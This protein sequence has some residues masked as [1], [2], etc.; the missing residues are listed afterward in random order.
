[1]TMRL[2]KQ[3]ALA[4]GIL[5]LLQSAYA[6]SICI[7]NMSLLE[8][9]L[10]QRNARIYWA[11]GGVTE[12]FITEFS[13]ILQPC[14]ATDP[15]ARKQLADMK[16]QI[17]DS[18]KWCMSN[19]QQCRQH[20]E[21]G[22]GGVTETGEPTDRANRRAF[23]ILQEEVQKILSGVSS[24]NQSSMNSS[25]QVNMECNEK[26]KRAEGEIN[27]ASA[28]IPKG[29]AAHG[30]GVVMC[31]AQKEASIIRNS[32]TDSAENRD[33]IRSLKNIYQQ[34]ETA[35]RQL[36]TGNQ[37]PASSVC[38][39][40]IFDGIQQV[41][42]NSFGQTSQKSAQTQQAQQAA[43]Q[44]QQLAQQNQARADKARQG[45]RKTNNDAAQAHSCIEIDKEPG[46][47]GAFKNTCEYKVNFYTC[48]YKPKIK[49][50]GFNWSADFDCE[51]SQFGLHTPDG[52]RSVAAHN[53]NTEM[54]YWFACKA[55]AGPVDAVFVVGKGIEARCH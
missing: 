39:A 30:M 15:E 41:A 54:V 53:R 34:A 1:M 32:C 7:K 46:L 10:M 16:Q 42:N 36:G 51:K 31:G 49:E 27:A 12:K 17:A 43:Q 18:E 35:C 5:F 24:S 2:I 29:S 40:A 11:L 8:S 22:G 55:P 3:G 33:R 23:G 4:V 50:G 37:C 45:K 26:L 48:N 20:G 6:E 47:F 9:T 21:W 25:A 14:S 38:S 19:G 13:K 44:A 52:G 28:N